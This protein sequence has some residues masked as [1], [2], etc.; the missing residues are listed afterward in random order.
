MP[1]PAAV[2]FLA[3]DL[4][5]SCSAAPAPSVAKPEPE[6]LA[7]CLKRKGMRLFGAH[8]CKPCHDQLAL[9]G[10]DAHDVPYTDCQP[11][12]TFGNIPECDALGI[13]QYPT[14]RFPDGYKAL[15][16]RSLKWLSASTSCPL[17]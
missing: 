5:V 4:F 2:L 16:V 13:Q 12:G 1:R 3:F 9:F 10:K 11:E 17:R 14:W 6:S 15:G 7:R 8:W